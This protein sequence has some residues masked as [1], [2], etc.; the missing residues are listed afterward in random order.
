[1]YTLPHHCPPLTPL[2]WEVLWYCRIQGGNPIHLS[3]SRG[4]FPTELPSQHHAASFSGTQSKSPPGPFQILCT[5]TIDDGGPSRLSRPSHHLPLVSSLLFCS[6]CATWA[7]EHP[8]C[9][10]DI[11]PEPYPVE[12]PCEGIKTLLHKIRVSR[13]NQADV[14]IE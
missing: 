1:M 11:S 12:Q 9:L 10:P 2:N 13:C 6:N 7:A 3:L 8:E 4:G 5:A 14:C